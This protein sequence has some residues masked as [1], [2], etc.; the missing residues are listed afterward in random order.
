MTFTPGRQRREEGALLGELREE[1]VRTGLGLAPRETE[2]ISRVLAEA[3][4][5]TSIEAPLDHAVCQ[6]F[7]RAGGVEAALFG[8]SK[9]GR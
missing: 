2:G 1:L 3:V 5:S 9:R 4:A 6:G 8:E 7:G